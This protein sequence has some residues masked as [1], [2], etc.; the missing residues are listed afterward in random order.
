MPYDVVLGMR[1]PI[2]TLQDSKEEMQDNFDRDL[3]VFEAI[4]DDLTKKAE[5][6]GDT[7]LETP[8]VKLKGAPEDSSSQ[9][10]NSS[11]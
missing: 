6:T 10:D 9:A 4:A 5:E 2:K 1:A 7:G 3:K 11:N 8:P